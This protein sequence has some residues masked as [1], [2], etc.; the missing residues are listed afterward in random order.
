MRIRVSTDDR[1]VR[2]LREHASRTVPSARADLADALRDRTLSEIVR[3]A[4]VRSG[5]LRRG[6]QS[7]AGG[8]GPDGT[9]SEIDGPGRSRR[10]ATN[11]VGYGR[12][13]EYGTSR[14]PPQRIVGHA[15]RRVA[16]TA[17]TLFRLSSD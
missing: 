3:T 9:S 1:L 2:R 16:R 13:V 8:G 12:Y 4:P 15:L 14:Q 17:H 7:A 11:H 10:R 6:W 5:R